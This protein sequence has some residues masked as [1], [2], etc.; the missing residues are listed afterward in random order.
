[1]TLWDVFVPCLFKSS[2]WFFGS[3]RLAQLEKLHAT[4]IAI[5]VARGWS[6]VFFPFS[7]CSHFLPPCS[8][9]RFIHCGIARPF[10]SLS[11]LDSTRLDSTLLPIVLISSHLVSSRQ[12]R[13]GKERK[14]TARVSKSQADKK[15]DSLC[16]L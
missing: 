7:F 2:W 15:T 5:V 16:S 9:F 10:L 14:G 12:E 6:V 3:G 13:K 8:L 1:M 4:I 11:R